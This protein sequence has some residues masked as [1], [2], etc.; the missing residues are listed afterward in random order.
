MRDEATSA[1]ATWGDGNRVR[2]SGRLWKTVRPDDAPA[3]DAARAVLSR[4]A[5]HDRSVFGRAEAA[6]AAGLAV[7]RA[8]RG[9]VRVRTAPIVRLPGD[10]IVD[11]RTADCTVWVAGPLEAE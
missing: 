2:V 9:A 11:D 3:T 8:A 6:R 5:E 7:E 1:G 10:A 4:H